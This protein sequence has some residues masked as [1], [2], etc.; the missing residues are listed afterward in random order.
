[1]K[2][3]P[4]QHL[5]DRMAQNMPEQVAI[6]CGDTRVTYRELKQRTDKLSNLLLS[7]GAQKGAIVAILLDDKVDAITSIIAVLKA[8]AVF[9]PFD[10]LLPELRL[11][12][13]VREVAPE[14]FISDSN[15]LSRLNGFAQGKVLSLDKYRRLDQ[16]ALDDV[17]A[18]KPAAPPAPDDFCYIYFT[19]GSTGRPKSIAG[20][21]KGID[22]FIRWQIETLRIGRD[23]RVSQLL[24]LS[25]DGSLR[26]IF[27]PLCAGGTLCVPEHNDLVTDAKELVSWLDREAISV[28]HCVPTLFRALLNEELQP[29]Q[30]AALRYVLLAGE[31]LL[32]ADVGRWR[33]VFGDRVKLINLYGTSETTMAKFIYEVQPGDEKRWSVPIGKPMPGARALIVDEEERICPTGVIGEI[34]IGTPYRSHGYYKQ[35]ELTAEVFIQ[36]PFSTNPNDIVYKTGDLGRLLDDGNLELLGRKDQQV[37]IR[38]VRVELEELN[39]VVRSFPGVKEVAVIDRKDTSGGNFLCAYLVGNDD[40]SLDSL[41]AYLQERL[42]GAMVPSA[43]VVMEKLPR[44]VSGKIDRRAL[45]HLQERTG[46]GEYV[47]PQTATEQTVAGIWASLLGLP[48]ISLHDNFFELGGHSLLATQVMVRVRKTTGVELPLRALFEN[49]TVAKLAAHIDSSAP[50]STGSL[51]PIVPVSR[52]RELPLSFAQQRLWFM[53][54][55]KPGDPLY[56][57]F[58]A[59]LIS[60]PLDVRALE[61]SL[62]EIIRRHEVLHTVFDTVEGRPVQRVEPFTP[63]SLLSM[64]LSDVSQEERSSTLKQVAVDERERPFDLSRGPLM[65]ALLVVLGEQEHALL[66]TLHHIVSDGWSMGILCRE[67]QALYGAFASGAAAPLPPLPIQYADF[68]VWQ[69]EHLQGEALDEQLSYWRTQL[70]N[71]SSVLELPA[72]RRRPE[73]ASFRGARLTFELKQELAQ[74]LKTLSQ[75]EGVT[76]FMVLLAALD[77]LLYRYSGQTDIAVG[78][79]IANRNRDETEGLI[80]FF[81]NMLVMRTDLRGNPSFLELLQRV[82]QMTIAAY[83]HQ[84]VPFEQIIEMLQPQRSLNRTPLY[85]VEFTLQNAPVEPLEVRG[86]RFA[87]LDM[88]AMSAE[89]D[90]NLMMTETESGLAGYVIYAT[91]LFDATT[92]ERMMSH[93]SNLLEEIVKAPEQRIL[94]LP[95]TSGSETQQLLA[96]WGVT[97]MNAN[98]LVHQLFEEQVARTPEAIAV[99]FNDRTFTY[100]ELNQRANQ[101][102]RYLKRHHAQPETLVAF[103]LNPSFDLVV[104]VLAIL[105]AGAAFVPLDPSYPAE[106]LAFMLADAKASILLTREALPAELPQS[107]VKVINLEASAAEISDE[108]VYDPSITAGGDNLAYAIYTSGSTGQPNGVLITHDSLTKYSLAFSERIGLRASD[109]ILQFA[110]PSFDVALEE[111]FPALLCGATI[112]FGN[113]EDSIAPMD[114]LRVIERQKITGLELPTAYWHEWVRVLSARPT[115]MPETLRFV[116]IGG[117][118]VSSKLLAAWQSFGVPLIHVYGLTETTITSTVYDVPRSDQ[119]VDDL[120]LGQALTHTQIYLLDPYLRPVPPGITGEIYIGGDCLA[121]AYLNRP[122]LTAERFIPN[123]FSTT[124][125]ARMYKTGDLARSLANGQL[126]FTGRVDHQL[127]IRGYRIEPDGI[128]TLLKQH[129]L[130]QDA[131]VTLTAKGN[132]HNRLF[133]RGAD[134]AVLFADQNVIADKLA[135]LSTDE[136][137]RLFARLDALSEDESETILAMELQL[138]QERERTTIRRYPQFEVQLKLKDEEFIKPPKEA[139]RNWLLRRALDEFA[140]DLKHLDV[141]SRRFVAGSARPRLETVPWGSHHAEYD[142]H[143]LFIAGQQVMQDWELPLMDAMAKVV[144]ESHGDIL[145]AG[146]GMALSATCIQKYGVRSYTIMEANDEVVKRFHEW[147]KQ[148]PGRDIRLLHGRWHDTHHQ[149]PDESMDGVFFDTVPTFEDEYLREVIDNVVMAEDFFPVAARVLRP[150]GIFTWYTNEID[151][152][153]RRHQRL[154]QKYFRSFEVTVCRPLYPPEDC[155]YWFADSMVVVKAVK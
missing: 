13:M 25:F 146:F 59:L 50:E 33:A 100:A 83:Q 66:L 23:D 56:H 144:T 148:F 43:F 69:R 21:L 137:E 107:G 131:V 149:V 32:P 58:Q 65:R 104:A 4:V 73:I 9:V 90:L 84:D 29:E 67:M 82:K 39:S 92:I 141:V 145:E 74:Q 116:I 93:F 91:D 75:R 54:Q 12:T 53:E 38:G 24:P 16:L 71:V 126:L 70:A 14:L 123:P 79:A 150:G 138:D 26:D 47:A 118:K 133:K 115:Q 121:R 109:R 130:V 63:I 108:S 31:A 132:G 46:R 10:P 86:L 88:Q 94:E 64:N 61:L 52:D 139:Q 28:I 60:G 129:P 153:S 122:A 34:Y 8:G 30:F 40:L 22:H 57:S 112:V 152:L 97:D 143:N 106:T 85:Q 98:K 111:I 72:D 51:P 120:P 18:A 77:A 102:A 147:K 41:R 134:G 20:R 101:L 37:K 155:H 45:P 17:L 6:S 140:S 154:I 99:V 114:L 128:E 48:K 76:L 89:T 7:G 151:T 68:S 1:M 124:P 80:G 119:P 19:S 113:D 49:P 117:E 95:L 55:L 81:V 96:R 103:H 62:N 135:T 5:F 11:E 27:V 42:P 136:V 78:T 105:K 142:E 2:H 110:S 125:G 44:T 36:N 3:E 35:P 15:L 127:K 87:P